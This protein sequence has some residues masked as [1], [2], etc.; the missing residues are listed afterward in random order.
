MITGVLGDPGTA[1]T[2]LMSHFAKITKR[3]VL[4]NYK[5]YN[6]VSN[7]TE[8][9]WNYRPLVLSDLINDSEVKR[10]A[11]I[12]EIYQYA[13]SRNSQNVWNIL[14]SYC[15]FEHRK[16]QTDIMFSAQIF[17]VIDVRIREMCDIIIVGVRKEPPFVYNVYVKNK[18]IHYF[19][20]KLVLKEEYAKSIF[21]YFKTRQLIIS[22]RTRRMVANA[23]VVTDKDA[24]IIKHVKLC[25]EFLTKNGWDVTKDSVREYLDSQKDA[26]NIPSFANSIY[27]RLKPKPVKKK[28]AGVEV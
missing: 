24:G 15:T 25:Q 3:I 16:V 17:R 2:L 9:L 13:D 1:K 19:T 26:P 6:P 18:G 8:D 27:L 22:D 20:K 5:L 28:F 23:E 10:L 11:L 14:L 21:P 7:Y 4:S 12:D